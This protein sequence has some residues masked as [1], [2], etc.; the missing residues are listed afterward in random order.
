MRRRPARDL[1]LDPSPTHVRLEP[2]CSGSSGTSSPVAVAAMPRPRLRG[3]DARR[4]GRASRVTWTSS[5]RLSV[6]RRWRWRRRSTGSSSTGSSSSRSARS[7]SSPSPRRAS[8]SRARRWPARPTSTARSRPPGRARGRVGQDAAERALAPP[9]RARRRDRAEP[10]GAR[11]ARGAQRRQ[12]DLVGQGRA[13][14]ARRELPLLRL[15]DRARSRGRSNPLGGSLLLYSLKEPVG[16]AGQIVPWNYPLMMATWKLAPALAAG[17]TVVLKPD[18]ATPLTALR[19]AELAAEVGFPPGVVNVVPGDGPTTGALPRQPPG[20]RQGRVHRLD[21]DGRARSCGS[22]PTPIKR[23]HARARRQEPEPRLRR[24]RPRRRDPELGLVDL[25]LGR[26]EL[27]GALARARRAARSTT[28]S[29]RGSPRRRGR[30]KVGDP[31]DPETQ[32][33][34]LISQAHRDKVHGFVEQGRDEGAEVVTGG[35]PA[36]ARARS[37]RRPCSPASRTGW[38]SRRRRSSARSSR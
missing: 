14:Q 19:L 38:R 9:A 3:S 16:V 13:R 28:T 7:A 15:R 36:T 33:G 24:R 22:P 20:R 1:D 27:R 4:I 37:T 30:L 18:P 8:R 35:E 34:S 5:R 2:L 31:L 29:S 23:R 17:C 12:G 26:T 25:L 21:Q 32:M 6:P 11:R 10:Q